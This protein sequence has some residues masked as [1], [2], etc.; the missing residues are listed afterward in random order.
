MVRKYPSLFIIIIVAI[1]G[2]IALLSLANREIK[3]DEDLLGQVTFATLEK[4][5]KIS[6]TI[7]AKLVVKDTDGD[8]LSDSKERSLGTDSND[9]DTDDDGLSDG[10]EVNTYASDPLSEDGDNDGFL[11]YNEVHKYSTDPDDEEDHPYMVFATA[12]DGY[13]YALNAIDGY[14]LWK[15]T[16]KASSA[17][18]YYTITSSPTVAGGIV[19]FG[20]NDNYV[21]ALDVED[22]SEIW[23]FEIGADISSSPTVTDGVLYIGASDNYVYALD[24][25]TGSKL[26]SFETGDYIFGKPT[27]YNGVVY[28][29]SYD[30]YLYALDADDGAELWRFKAASNLRSTPAV[31]VSTP[32]VG[33]LPVTE[34]YIIS[35][36]VTGIGGYLYALN[37]DDGTELWS[38]SIVGQMI[39]SAVVDN[40][41][42]YFG[43]YDKYV[44]ALNINDKSEVWSYPTAGQV[45]N[46]PTIKDGV[47]YIGDDSGFVYAL[48]SN[49]GSR[50]WVSL[51]NSESKVQYAPQVLGSMV[52]VNLYNHE[53]IFALDR[54]GGGVQWYFRTGD[55][56]LS[57][58]AV[59]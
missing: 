52:Y 7:K 34:I 10:E 37:A 49:D 35:M 15:A 5:T 51:T 19:Y 55:S 57:G 6:G 18:T 22:G 30:N 13:I 24:A 11:D 8:G 47:L 9:A 41:Y 45:S 31:A 25:D 38:Q 21:Y 54:T 3:F 4:E 29:G 43:T 17:S 59:Y 14:V 27:V 1:V 23:S 16:T 48:N 28:I 58:L 42:V 53:L 2:V 56:M 44:H 46:T 40:G 39:H 20:G 36:S 32:T 12:T 50:V 26:W 33:G